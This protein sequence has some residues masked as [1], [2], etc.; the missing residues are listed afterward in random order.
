MSWK[1][2]VIAT[3][4]ERMASYYSYGISEPASMF[5]EIDW[6]SAAAGK[7]FVNRHNFVPSDQADRLIRWVRN[8]VKMIGREILE[9]H[10]DSAF[11]FINYRVLKLDA[12]KTMRCYWLYPGQDSVEFR[13]VKFPVTKDISTKQTKR[14]QLFFKLGSNDPVTI[15]SSISIPGPYPDIYFSSGTIA[16]QSCYFSKS[17]FPNNITLDKRA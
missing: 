4:R 12:E 3:Q 6:T 17:Y 8:T 9:G 11:M 15:L 10:T 5:V 7:V 1:G 16:G 2:M 13:E 14:N